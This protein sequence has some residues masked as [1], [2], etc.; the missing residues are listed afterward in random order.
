MEEKQRRI[1]IKETFDAVSEGYD[2][3]ALRIFPESAEYFASILGLRGNEHVLDVAAGTGHST[4]A[5][6]RYLPQGHVTGVDFSKGMLDKARKKAAS[7]N[8]KNVEFLEMDMQAMKFAARFDAAICAFGIFFVDDMNTQ[9]KHIAE[10]VRNGGT[11]AICNFQKNYFQPLRDLMAKRLATYNIRQSTPAITRIATEAAC[12]E[13]FKNAGIRDVRIEQK[14]M[15]YYLENETDWWDIIWNIA[16][17]RMLSKLQ[18][19]DMERFKKE[20]MQEVASLAT[21]E[22]IWL[23]IGVLYT[24]GVK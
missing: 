1:V 20:H 21:K 5:L 24:I 16:L 23:D 9:L 17:R 6:S 7:M 13:L 8:I 10:M 19:Q 4:F 11:V 18:Q 22:G 15:G 3:K 14:N 12:K 2:N